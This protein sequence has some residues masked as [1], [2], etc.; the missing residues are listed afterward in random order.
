MKEKST[1]E[2]IGAQVAEERRRSPEKLVVLKGDQRITYGK[3]RILMETLNKAGVEDIQLG[4]D[5][6]KRKD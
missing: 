4:T 2:R 5:E 3:A 1:L 6:P